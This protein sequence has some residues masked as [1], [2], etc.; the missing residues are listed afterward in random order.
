M[1]VPLLAKNGN[2]IENQAPEEPKAEDI[3]IH[4]PVDKPLPETLA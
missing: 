2:V 4:K 3:L 1:V